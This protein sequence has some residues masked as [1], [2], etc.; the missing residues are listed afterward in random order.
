M[1]CF[2]AAGDGSH[3]QNSRD[4]TRSVHFFLSCILEG[5]RG[6]VVSVK[7]YTI[8]K[9]HY[10]LLTPRR[11]EGGGQIRIIVTTSHM[12]HWVFIMYL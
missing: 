3:A 7:S 1:P 10:M 8:Y 5:T 9:H 12:F 4:R 6:R 2:T 11:L